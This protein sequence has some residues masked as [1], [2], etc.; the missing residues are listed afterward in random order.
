MDFIPDIV[1]FLT[2]PSGTG[3]PLLIA[4]GLG[5]IM[6]LMNFTTK[7]Q[8]KADEAIEGKKDKYRDTDI[9]FKPF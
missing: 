3:F 6:Y 4:G 2:D 7:E 9:P 8:K 5:L 1:D